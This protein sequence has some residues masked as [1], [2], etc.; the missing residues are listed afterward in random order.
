MRKFFGDRSLADIDAKWVTDYRNHLAETEGQFSKLVARAPGFEP[1]A[2]C[3]QAKRT[4]SWNSFLFN[5]VFENKRVRKI[6]G[7][8]TM[9]GNAPPHASGPPN[10]PHSEA[11]AKL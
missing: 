11:K 5:L 3:A 1:G 8:G 10:F 2:P 4:I 6:F 7:S 9:Y